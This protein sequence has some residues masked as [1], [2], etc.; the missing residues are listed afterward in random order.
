MKS[1]FVGIICFLLGAIGV[2]AAQRISGGSATI[3]WEIDPGATV[4]N[5]AYATQGA[6]ICVT[7]TNRCR[8]RVLT[9]TSSTTATLDGVAIGSLPTALAAFCDGIFGAAPSF[10]SRRTAMLNAA[11]VKALLVGP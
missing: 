6:Q 1:A 7:G 10:T 9:C 8:S 3:D 5:G 11:G 4:V 2:S